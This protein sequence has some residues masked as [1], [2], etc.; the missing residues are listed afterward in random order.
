MICE[1]K[2]TLDKVTGTKSILEKPFL[3]ILFLP[4]LEISISLITKKQLIIFLY[5]SRDLHLPSLFPLFLGLIRFNQLIKKI[6]E[7]QKRK[8]ES[9]L[10]TSSFHLF[11]GFYLAFLPLDMA[12]YYLLNKTFGKIKQYYSLNWA[13]LNKRKLVILSFS[14]IGI[15]LVTVGFLFWFFRF[16]GL[17]SKLVIYRT[18]KKKRERRTLKDIEQLVKGSR[19]NQNR[20]KRK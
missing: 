12:V 5:L 15:I 16:S 20:K 9:Y 8:E 14:L 1:I 13:K 17:G 4:Q 18:R 3:D 11:F 19:L 7:R 6:W 2:R 10:I